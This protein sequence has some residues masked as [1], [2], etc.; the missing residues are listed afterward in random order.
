MVD[1]YSKL[2][3]ALRYCGKDGEKHCKSIYE[4]CSD[5]SSLA[6]MDSSVISR[7]SSDKCAVMINI[8]SAIASRIGTEAFKFGRAHTEEEIERFLSSYYLN[9]VNETLL[10]LPLD[11]RNRVICAEKVVE[12]TINF[13]SVLPRKFLEIMLRYG[14]SKAIIAHNHPGGKAKPSAEDVETTAVIRELF[15]TTGRELVC[16]YVVAGNDV[17]KVV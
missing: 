3:A 14:S 16:H 13:S 12:G 15:S 9:I 2:S 10:I 7:I 17:S 5:F 11:D 4:R 8:I 6:S 1:F